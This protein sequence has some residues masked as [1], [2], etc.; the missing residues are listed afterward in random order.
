M[1]VIFTLFSVILAAGLNNNKNLTHNKSIHNLK[2][3]LVICSAI[4]MHANEIHV[5]LN[6]TVRA[7]DLQF[8]GPN[9]SPTLTASW[10]F[11]R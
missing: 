4:Y 1:H 8:G 2:K 5:I 7:L 6:R 9:S 3:G 10:I 11:P